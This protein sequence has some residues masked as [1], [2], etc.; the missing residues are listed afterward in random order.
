MAKADKTYGHKQSQRRLEHY[1]I[2]WD[3]CN[4]ADKIQ[5]SIDTWRHRAFYCK[6]LIVLM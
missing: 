5:Y 3:T 1:G 2:I 4:S 6:S